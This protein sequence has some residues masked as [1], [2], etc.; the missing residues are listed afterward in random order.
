MQNMPTNKTV[1]RLAVAIIG[2]VILCSFGTVL[3]GLS[4]QDFQKISSYGLVRYQSIVPPDGF[5]YHSVGF[6]YSS[7]EPNVTYNVRV[8]IENFTQMVGKG[9]YAYSS[10]AGLTWM[11]NEPFW[12]ISPGKNNHEP[13][14]DEGL[15][16]AMV[17]ILWPCL[18]GQ[19]NDDFT[20]KQIAN[21]TY[22][23]FIKAQA[24]LV[25]AF[26]H[27]F[28]IRFGHEFNILQGSE[29]WNGAY[30]WARNP[31]DFVNAWRRYVTIFRAEGASNAIFVWNANW[32]DIGPHHWTEY[33]PGDDYVDW[34]GVD[35]YQYTPSSD[36]AQEMAGIYNDY[37]SKKPIVIN[38]WGA[39]WEGQ[40]YSDSVRASFINR[41]FDA[42][43]SR[44]KIKMIN[45]WYSGD[46]RFDPATL[47]LTT[48]AYANR[49]SNTRYIC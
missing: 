44:P 39:N 41:F 48:A 22:D 7:T 6:L 23:D 24:D 1:K 5:C 31:A 32:E 11:P 37:R 42:V 29:Y 45:Y 15:I 17:V 25:K 19:V 33:Y 4:L 20:V 21:G 8:Q 26:E 9:A 30:S 35:L 47:P 14:V 49:I 18:R 10:A 16:K 28:F 38:E 12:E 43:E 40:N 13:L 27:P 36:P 2:A 34:V 46:F 3:P